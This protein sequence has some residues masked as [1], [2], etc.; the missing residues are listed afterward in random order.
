MPGLLAG[1]KGRIKVENN[2]VKKAEETKN[3]KRGRKPRDPNMLTQAL[4]LQILKPADP[5]ITWQELRKALTKASK[6]SAVVANNCMTQYYLHAISKEKVDTNTLYSTLRN[7]RPELSSSIVN[8]IMQQVGQY[9][10]TYQY[11]TMTGERS[12]ASFKRAFPLLINNQNYQNTV[13]WDGSECT[14]SIPMFSRKILDANP[15][16]TAKKKTKREKDLEEEKNE[17]PLQLSYKIVAVVK[18]KAHK[19]ILNRLM[20]GE[21]KFGQMKVIEKRNKFYCTINYKFPKVAPVL[22]PNR[23]M[24]IDLGVA[25]IAYYAFNFSPK[26]GAIKGGEVAAFSAK[27]HNLR[28]SYQEQGKYCGEGRIGHGRKRRLRPIESINEKEKNFRD[29]TNHRYSKYLVEMAL[30]NNCGKIQMEELSGIKKDKT[31]L[32]YWDYYSLQEKI[33]YKAEA[34]GIEV[35]LVDPRYT[36]QR[37]SRCGYIDANNRPDQATFKCGKCRYGD[38]YYCYTCGH[39]QDENGSCSN[40]G[41]EVVKSVIHADYNA[42]KNLSTPD[43]DTIIE[44]EM[45]ANPKRSKKKR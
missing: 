31:Y 6:M 22:D 41:S 45:G 4:S 42:A 38:N 26:R 24:G 11:E 35:N 30:K 3:S 25:N 13:T 14:L 34:V 27:I 9:W 37:C 17:K 32:Q 19:E 21:Y 18:H 33:R 29:L 16:E 36:S 10:R 5:G 2:Q 40:C 1:Q 23:I 28:R 15:E 12:L 7:I 43:I 39:E 20:S 8:Q 44:K